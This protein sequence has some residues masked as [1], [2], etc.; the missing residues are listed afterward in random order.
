MGVLHGVVSILI[1]EVSTLVGRIGGVMPLSTSVVP[2]GL[3]FSWDIVG[4]LPDTLTCGIVVPV[5]LPFTR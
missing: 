3:C 2:V 5:S 4:M 1:A